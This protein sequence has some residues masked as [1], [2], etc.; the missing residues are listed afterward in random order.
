MAPMIAMIST[1]QHH[2]TNRKEGRVAV[3]RLASDIRAGRR[4]CGS[5]LVG[6]VQIVQEIAPA[7]TRAG[8]R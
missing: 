5:S 4:P 7:L 2:A 6:P 1:R 3:E 8:P